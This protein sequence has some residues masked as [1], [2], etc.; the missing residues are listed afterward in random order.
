MESEET[1]REIVRTI[2]KRIESGHHTAYVSSLCL[3]EVLSDPYRRE[4]F[5]LINDYKSLLTDFPHLKIFPVDIAIADLA[6]QLR[7]RYGLRTPDA[8]HLGT[9]LQY[10]ASAFITN[11]KE[12]RRVK[13]LPILLLSDYT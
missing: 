3:T 7:A 11:D 4:K 10:G 5:A 6:A 2:L 9:A 1:Y 8:L 13:E 12:L